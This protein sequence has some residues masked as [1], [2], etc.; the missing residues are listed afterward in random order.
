MAVLAKRLREEVEE[1]GLLLPNQIGFR[2][3]LGIMDNICMLKYLINRQINREIERLMVFFVDLKAAFDLVLV[4]T[5][6]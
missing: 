1:K 6:C 5:K 3:R 4:E 2:K